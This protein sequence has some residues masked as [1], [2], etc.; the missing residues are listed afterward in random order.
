MPV[1]LSRRAVLLGGGGL[2][3]AGAA[4]GADRSSSDD[5]AGADLGDDVALAAFFATNEPFAAAAID[6]RVV[7]GL[8]DANGPIGT[9]TPAE[10]SFTLEDATGSPAGD[11]LVVARHQ[12]ELP[13][14]YYPVRFNVAE[15][16][17][18]TA[19][20]EVGGRRLETPFLVVA[21]DQVA[22]PQVGDQLPVTATPTTDDPRGVDPICTRD[23]E[24]PLHE[25]SLDE[26]AG[27]GRPVALLVSTPAFCQTAICGPVLDV[28]LNRRAEVGD[29]VT[30]LHA[31][32]YADDTASE[33]AP[34]VQTLRLSYEPAL[35]VVDGDGVLRARLDNI[36][37][38]DEMREALAA[39]S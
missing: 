28:L 25:V 24:C 38:A 2:V 13:R 37:D 17:S 7:F 5:D 31:E 23:P 11:A 35:F 15:P 16:G 1:R 22:I 19:V 10:L 12:A 26:V 39:V 14:P 21:R 29:D 8:V 27:S 36:F 6:Q 20:T 3:L 30:L 4:C 34:I 32:V 9:G 33:L 18:Y